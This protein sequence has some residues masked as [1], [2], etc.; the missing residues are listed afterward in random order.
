MSE[1]L[2]S[3]DIEK[4][5]I[6]QGIWREKQ[7]RILKTKKVLIKQMWRFT[8]SQRKEINKYDYPVD[9]PQDYEISFLDFLLCG[10]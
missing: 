5:G 2:N 3:E 8:R 9:D 6:Q 7:K 1:T 10:I 4:L